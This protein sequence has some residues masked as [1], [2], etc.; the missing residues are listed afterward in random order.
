MG[1]KNKELIVGE[2]TIEAK[3]NR[4]IDRE[5]SKVK[6]IVTVNI[7]NSFA[8]HGIKVVDSKNGL[9]VQMPQREYEDKGR[10]MFA[11]IFHPI[12]LDA[13]ALITDEVFKA[14]DAKLNE[15]QDFADEISEEL[16]FNQSM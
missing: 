9:F 10:R 4:L 6:A 14:F 3:V 15:Y 2:P 7:G 16:P 5:D 13:R 12:T 11:D 8:I 1:Q